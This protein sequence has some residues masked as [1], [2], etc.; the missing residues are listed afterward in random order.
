MKDL[1]LQARVVVRTS[2]MEFS[3]PHLADYVKKIPLKSVPHV[4]HDYFSSSIQ[5]IKS[6]DLKLPNKVSNGFT[7]ESKVEGKLS[8]LV[9]SFFFLPPGFLLD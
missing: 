9:F 2:N 8:S 7:G 5:P 3:C 1:L 6:S 4:Q